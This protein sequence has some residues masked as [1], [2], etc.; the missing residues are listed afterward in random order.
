MP[1]FRNFDDLNTHLEACC[2]KR[3]AEQLRGHDQTV[4][5]RLGIS[6][7]NRH[8]RR[9]ATLSGRSAPITPPH[10]SAA[11]AVVFLEVL[12]SHGDRRTA[13]SVLERSRLDQVALPFSSAAEPCV[14]GVSAAYLKR[15]WAKPGSGNTCRELLP[16]RRAAY[17]NASRRDPRSVPGPPVEKRPP[18][19]PLSDRQQPRP[20][21]GLLKGQRR[22]HTST[23][24]M[25]ARPSTLTGPP[26]R[27]RDHVPH[28]DD[29]RPRRI[30][31][32]VASMHTLIIANPPER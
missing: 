17:R 28:H 25:A 3:W 13:T 27:G 8:A 22:R 12:P 29:E 30:D 2:A 4:G 6:S 14:S 31:G 20:A 11:C 18:A 15:G 23:Q 26:E 21:V 7:R 5:E 1:R 9:A 16:R 10:G 24:R 32:Q 19:G